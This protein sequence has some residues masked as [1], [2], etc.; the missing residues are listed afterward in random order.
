MKQ[1]AQGSGGITIRLGV[2][3]MTGCGNH[4]YGLID[5]LVLA[6]RLDSMV[7]EAFSKLYDSMIL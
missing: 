3:E 4:C 5:M 1:T 6:Q 7:L 2:R